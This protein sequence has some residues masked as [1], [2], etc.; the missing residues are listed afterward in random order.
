V[1]STQVALREEIDEERLIASAQRG[2]LDAF[3]ELVLAYQDQVYNL[4]YRIMG[5]PASASDATQEAFIS[6]YQN[7]ERF[8]GKHPSSFKSWLMRIVSNACYDELR[9]RK[10]QPATSIEDFEIDEEANPAL[11]S[12]TEGPEEYAE[13]EEMARVIE[14]G[15]QALPLDQRVTLVLA[16]VQGFSYDEIAEATDAPLGTV[17]SRLARAR[18]KLRD[19]L[20]ERAELLPAQYR[21]K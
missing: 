15:I 20:R 6:A 12:E 17:K 16:D 18:A 9:R 13:R 4:A 2:N 7:I 5:D 8:R 10:R 14:T 21:L 3:N 1:V 19:Y 11:I